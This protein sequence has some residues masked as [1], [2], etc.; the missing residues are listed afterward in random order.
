MVGGGE[1]QG[2]VGSSPEKRPLNS[3][4]A[5]GWV[6]PRAIVDVMAKENT[7]CRK[8]WLVTRVHN[9]GCP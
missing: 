9:M 3:Y 2:T 7:S 8:S 6:S 5:G 1:L 4:S